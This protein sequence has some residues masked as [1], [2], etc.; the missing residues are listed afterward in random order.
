MRSRCLLRDH[1][2]RLFPALLARTAARQAKSERRSAKSLESCAGYAAGVRT[3][4]SAPWWARAWN[5]YGKRSCGSAHSSGMKGAMGTTG[6]H[7]L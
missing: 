3:L 6:H 1:R 4:E 5:A 2:H 7:I